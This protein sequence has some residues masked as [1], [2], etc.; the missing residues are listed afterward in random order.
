M[1]NPLVITNCWPCTAKSIWVQSWRTL[2]LAISIRWGRFKMSYWFVCDPDGIAHHVSNLKV[3]TVP[4]NTYCLGLM[5]LW[6]FMQIWSTYWWLL[7]NSECKYFYYKCCSAEEWL[8]I[9]MHSCRFPGQIEH[10][11]STFGRFAAAVATKTLTTQRGLYFCH[12][13]A[14]GLG[15]SRSVFEFVGPGLGGPRSLVKFH[16]RSCISS[17]RYMIKSEYWVITSELEC[18]DGRLW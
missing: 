14:I 4:D 1:L 5:S 18:A 13:G 6:N 2:L 10:T 17:E 9:Y 3:I 8:T 15:R 7:A 11:I 16:G 12:G